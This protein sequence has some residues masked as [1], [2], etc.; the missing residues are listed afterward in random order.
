MFFQTKFLHQKIYSQFINEILSAVDPAN[1]VQKNLI[2]RG[3][4][5]ISGNDKY[6]LKDNSEIYLFGIGKATVPMGYAAASILNSRL[7]SGLLIAKHQERI[8]RFREPKN[9]KVMIGDHPIPS[10][11]SVSAG[12]GLLDFLEQSKPGDLVIGLISGGG[13]A[14]VTFPRLPITISQINQLTRDLILS[15]ANI[16]EINIIRKHLD[17][18]KGGGL[19]SKIYPANSLNLILS[20]VIGDDLSVIASGPTCADP[21][22]FFDA[23]N[24]IRKYR[25]EN[26][27]N[28]DIISLLKDGIQGKIPETVKE[29]NSLLNISKNR[30]VGNLKIAAKAS[31][32]TAEKNGFHTEIY[33][34]TLKGEARDVG[35]S[36]AKYLIQRAE[37]SENTGKP[38]CIIAGGETTVTVT[39]NGKGGR[40]Q[41]IALSAAIELSGRKD[42][43]I[44][45]LATDGEDGPT[46]A[47]GALVDGNTIIKGE[48]LGIQARNAMT[49]NDSYYFL[50]KTSCLIKTG[51]TGTNVNDLVLMFA[52]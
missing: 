7:H 26:K 14:L 15:G 10:G 22:T 44:L 33:D 8:L 2:L 18:I 5:V 39:G 31:I 45:T 25:L 11:N 46:D 17:H 36:L 1:I 27:D 4:T 52:Y 9:V 48:R 49:N 23:L 41:E 3:D 47:A 16:N 29:G 28:E 40:N 35:S 21:S 43:Q 37:F 6:R 20:D 42:L 12:N 13:S 19:L 34:L 51:P 38:I 24:V 32:N 30:I 50:D